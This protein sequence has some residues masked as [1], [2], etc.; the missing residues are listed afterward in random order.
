MALSRQ[1]VFA[2][3]LL[4]ARFGTA[5]PAAEKRFDLTSLRKIVRVSDPQ[6]SPDGTHVVISV[7][8]PNY[9]DNRHDAQLVLVEVATGFQQA[10]TS[11]RRGVSSPRWSPAGDRLAFLATGTGAKPQI[12]VLPM[13]GGDASQV[14][15]APNG[16]QQF[17]WRP[18]G[19]AFAY[20]SADEP[21]KR[22]GEERHNDSFEVGN[23]DFLVT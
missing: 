8:R 18:D 9:E 4:A 20:A 14:T 22:T 7:S 17:A 5:A 3:F 2:V 13:N 11:E 19:K 6:V 21:P 12:F 1:L 15:R 10:L 16:V 23:D